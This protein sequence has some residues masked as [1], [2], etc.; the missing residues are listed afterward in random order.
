MDDTN[1]DVNNVFVRDGMLGKVSEC[2]SL[3]KAHNK[4]FE[5]LQWMPFQGHGGAIGFAVI[6]RR[7]SVFHDKPGEHFAKYGVWDFHQDLFIKLFESDGD[8]VKEGVDEGGVHVYDIIA[9]FEGHA[10]LMLA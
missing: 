7:A 4:Q 1:T 8:E 2:C 9:F 5:S 10:T 6:G 3:D